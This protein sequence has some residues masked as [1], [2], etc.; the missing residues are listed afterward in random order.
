MELK[1]R[2]IIVI[3]AL[4]GALAGLGLWAGY[5]ARDIQGP[6]DLRVDRQNQLHIRVGENNFVYDSDYQLRDLYALGHYGISG[7]WGNYAFFPNND[8][9][10]SPYGFIPPQKGSSGRLVRC[11]ADSGQCRVLDGFKHRFEHSFRSYIDESGNVYIADTATGDVIWLDEN[12]VELAR[13]GRRL[14][15]PNQLRRYADELV[16]AQFNAESLLI[17]PLVGQSFAGEDQWRNLSLDSAANRAHRETRP[18]DFLRLDDEWFVLAKK[19]DA[20]SGSIYHFNTEAEYLGRFP[21]PASADPLG[22]ADFA[23]EILVLDYAGMEVRR[24]ARDGVDLGV[25]SSPQQATF[26]DALLERRWQFQLLGYAAWGVFALA[27]A[28]GLAF[29][30]RMELGKAAQGK[31]AASADAPEPQ[32]ATSKPH[33]R[34][35]RIHWIEP[36]KTMLRAMMVTIPLVA[37]IPL[38]SRLYSP[39]SLDPAGQ[40]DSFRLSFIL[41]AFTG[42]TLAV[43]VP[44]FLLL[45]RVVATRIGVLDEWVL[46]DRGAAG[47]LIA[48][49]EDLFSVRN[50]FI[51][52]NTT[53]ALGNMQA[54]VYDWKELTQWLTPRLVRAKTLTVG[55]QL[56]WQWQNQRTTVVLTLFGIG[57]AL[58]LIVAIESGYFKAQVDA[59]I[60]RQPACASVQG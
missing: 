6:V 37:C 45:K 40:C 54:S 20:R 22:M 48:R 27:L 14:D 5:Q 42:I 2:L 58:A 12:G 60:L 15:R 25:V 9:L 47:V 18:V 33:F 55:Q 59:W 8:M 11:N 17:V 52:H 50:A 28:A 49:D 36:R 31:A 43:L 4:F 13:L 24:Y 29:A 19:Q 34:D 16:V 53:I 39:E 3:V 56:V 35:S 23:G 21:I 44:V 26:I 32:R 1:P 57:L 46:V 10:L 41:W 38:L 7:L 30:L 51:I